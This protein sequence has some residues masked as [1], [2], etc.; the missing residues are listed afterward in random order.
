[1]KSTRNLFLI[2]ATSVLAACAATPP[3][4]QKTAGTTEPSP[5]CLKTTGSNI[6]RAQGTSNMNNVVTISGEDL[7]RSG[8]PI[9]G[10]TPGKTGD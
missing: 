3:A 1:M 9:T 8:G 5:E 10:A 2:T 7:R 4:D 6:C